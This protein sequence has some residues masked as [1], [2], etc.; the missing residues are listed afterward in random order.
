MRWLCIEAHLLAGRYHGRGDEGRRAEWPPNPHRVFQALIAAANLG[1]RRTEFSDAKKEAFRWLERRAPPEIIVPRAHEANVVRL[2]VPNNDMDKV[3][4]A[5]ARG[6]EPE[7]QPSELRTDK[8]LRPQLLDGDATARFLWK[9]MDEEWDA[10][11]PQAE[12]LCAEARHLHALGLGIDLVAGNG[13]I[14]SETEKQGFPG[15]VYIADI[16][17]KGWRVPT[18]GSIDELLARHAEQKQR[19]QVGRG[20][21]AKRWVALP[22][23]LKVF[24]EVAYLHQSAG[25]YRPVH[26]F[27]LVDED[28]AYRSFDPRQAI[29]VA[30]WLRHA[31]HER[32]RGLKLDKAFIER[33][34]CGHGDDAEAKNDRFSY[35]PLPTIPAKGRDGRIRRVLLAEPFG[36]GGGKAQAVARRL[37]GASLVA[38]GTGEIMADLRVLADPFADG[39]SVRYLRKAQRWGSVTPLVLPGRDD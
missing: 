36:G 3:A 16:D 21:G 22:A 23:P 31:A 29:E 8:D 18:E 24:R 17:G 35:L 27:T 1:F 26:A 19:V 28:G 32:A 10:T 20:L 13:R 38:E 7:K 2:Y 25:R 37:S 6:V 11:R 15:D 14:L 34:V 9:I 4:R 39:V 12:L 30:A 33:F 5:W